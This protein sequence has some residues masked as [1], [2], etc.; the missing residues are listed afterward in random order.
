MTLPMPIKL[1]SS[2]TQIANRV[3]GSPNRAAIGVFELRPAATRSAQY[4]SAPGTSDFNSIS[5]TFGHAPIKVFKC[6]WPGILMPVPGGLVGKSGMREFHP[7]TAILWGEFKR[8]D[9]FSALRTR[10][11]G[12]PRQ[13][14]QF[15]GH[16]LQK[17]AVMGMALPVEMRFEE[18][19]D[20]HLSCHYEGA[21]FG[22]PLIE[23][24]RP[25]TINHAWGHAQRA[26]NRELM[27][28]R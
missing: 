14:Q 21:R 12:D 4:S 25:G 13:A 15:V 8:N 18:K 5:D 11:S 28:T 10:V 9:G 22:E 23:V 7:R 26:L 16:Q 24:F 6:Q 20:I 1:P 27:R 17:S 19:R 2:R 3:P